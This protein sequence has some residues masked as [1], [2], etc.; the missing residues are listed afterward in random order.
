MKWFNAFE[1]MN[2]NRLWWVIGIIT[3]LWLGLAT[4]VP[5][6]YFRVVS[7]ILSALQSAFLF[8]SRGTK[9]VADRSELPP[10]GKV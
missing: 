5:E 3:T 2:W 6:P 1:H 10:D 7:V 4:V 8:A 9:Y